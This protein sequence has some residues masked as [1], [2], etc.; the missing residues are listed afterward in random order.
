[1]NLMDMFKEV[2][3]TLDS[4]TG[5][6][7]TH[8]EFRS[9]LP[10]A[11]RVINSSSEKRNELVRAYRDEGNPDIISEQLD[12]MIPEDPFYIGRYS[13][14]FELTCIEEDNAIVLPSTW[15][16]LLDIY[17]K[18]DKMR[19]VSLSLLNNSG[20]D[21]QYCSIGNMVYFNLDVMSPTLDLVFRVRTDFPMPD[22]NEENYTGMPEYGYPL[23]IAAVVL[24]LSSRPR[25]FD[26]NLYGIHQ[27]R[28]DEALSAFSLRNITR[29][30]TAR[31]EPR[32]TYN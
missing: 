1:M 25:F 8:G 10:A 13:A 11:V 32:F 22:M 23:L 27:A 15:S 29:E 28:Y 17:N 9:A 14:H 3:I 12:H 30:K 31:Q 20:D 19:P 2:Q 6:L 16:K 7:L 5:K 18:R 21:V 4:G 26:R 24:T